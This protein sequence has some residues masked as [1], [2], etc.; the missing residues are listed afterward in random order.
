[1]VEKKKISRYYH[2]FGKYAFWASFDQITRVC[3]YP[4]ARLVAGNG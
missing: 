4:V 2:E 1:M 3:W